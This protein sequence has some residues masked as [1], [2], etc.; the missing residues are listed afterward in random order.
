MHFPDRTS[1]VVTIVTTGPVVD[2]YTPARRS[3]QQLRNTLRVNTV[4]STLGGV[5]AAAAAG[6]MADLFDTGHAGWYRVVGLGLVAFGVVVGA[7]GGSRLSRLLRWA[8]VISAGDA[9][10]TVASFVTVAL[11]WYSPIGA[12]VVVAVAVVVGGLGLRQAITARRTRSL[13]GPRLAAMDEAPP[14][15]VVHVDRVVEGDVTT[16]W[17]VITDHELYGRLAPNLSRVHAETGN[18]ADLTRTCTNRSGGRW[19]E[20]C[21]LWDEER[22]YEVA[23]DTSN[24]PYP[25]AAMRG[26]WSVE[27]DVPGHV[28]VGMDFRFQPRRSLW[29]RVFAAAMNAAF[30]VVLGRILRGWQRAMR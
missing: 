11:G 22:R 10:W 28:R 14:V 2:E 26:S 20:T 9:G 24:Y 1:H 21:T 6:P 27:P 30:P 23:V 13:V 12:T 5:V 29:G 25:L 18:G 17:Q 15:E 3:A 4:T 19:H 8:P 16:A 7:V